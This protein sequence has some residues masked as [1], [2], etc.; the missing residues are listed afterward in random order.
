MQV[1]GEPVHSFRGGNDSRRLDLVRPFRRLIVLLFIL[2]G[3]MAHQFPLCVE[4]IENDFIL[5]GDLQVIIDDRSGRRI[6]A[7]G[8]SLIDLG[9]VMQTQRGLRLIEQRIHLRGLRIHLTQ[10][11]DVIQDPE[12]AAMGGDHDI[13]IFHDQIM[14]RRDWQI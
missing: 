11:R 3:K 2:A 9:R 10:R 14:D 4:D 13:V 8:L 12:R 5:R 6:L 7:D 1:P